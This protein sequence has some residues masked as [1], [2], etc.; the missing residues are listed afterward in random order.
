MGRV[1]G[2]PVFAS[3]QKIGL[4]RVFFRS[5]QKILTHFAMSMQRAVLAL[6]E[7]V[8]FLEMNTA[9]GCLGFR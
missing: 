9:I 8:G 7:V 3:G 6:L 4:G 1:T 2:Q 5:G